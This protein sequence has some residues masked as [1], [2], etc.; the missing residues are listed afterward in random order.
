MTTAAA[1]D[2]DDVSILSFV[3]FPWYSL[4][5]PH[6][7]D[8]ATTLKSPQPGSATCTTDASCNWSQGPCLGRGFG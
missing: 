7:I 8:A 3:L 2:D 6:S 5:F 1:A 4:R